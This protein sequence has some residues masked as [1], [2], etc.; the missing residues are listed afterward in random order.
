MRNMPAMEQ[1]DRPMSIGEV[2]RLTETPITTLR[3]YE[4][5]GLLP[6]PDRVGGQRRYPS[7]VAMRMMVIRY[8]RTA[9]LTLDEIAV[10]LDDRSPGRSITKQLGRER[11]RA[12]EDQIAQLQT[13]HRMVAAAIACGCPTVDVCECGAMDAVRAEIEATM[14]ATPR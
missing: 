12:I 7:S 1:S 9:G 4:R 6:P 8:C 13:A 3:Y 14:S 10:V 2:S 5:R 11:L